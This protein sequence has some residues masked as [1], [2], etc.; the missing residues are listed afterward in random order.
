MVATGPRFIA[1]MD[2]LPHLGMDHRVCGGFIA[3]S[4]TVVAL[5]ALGIVYQ[6][7]VGTSLIWLGETLAGKTKASAVEPDKQAALPSPM[8]PP[9]AIRRMPLPIRLRTRMYPIGRSAPANH[10]RISGALEL[11]KSRAEY[12]QTAMAAGS[13]FLERQ[14]MPPKDRGCLQCGR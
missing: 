12:R 14:G 9:T 3:I 6:R 13:R 8:R 10:V 11:P 5:A 7:D 4:A 1:T 2:R